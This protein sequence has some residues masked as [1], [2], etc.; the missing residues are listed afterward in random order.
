MV[1]HRD[2]SAEGLID[3]KAALRRIGDGHAITKV[4]LLRHRAQDD[5]EAHASQAQGDQDSCAN[6]C[7]IPSRKPELG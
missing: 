5:Q 1:A 3:V 2:R 7:T 4:G 6:V